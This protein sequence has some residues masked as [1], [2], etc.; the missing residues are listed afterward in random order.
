MGSPQGHRL[1]AYFPWATLA[2]LPVRR[3]GSALRISSLRQDTTLAGWQTHHSLRF[4]FIILGAGVVL[5][6]LVDCLGALWRHCT[7]PAQDV[8]QDLSLEDLVRGS[9]L[10]DA[11]KSKFVEELT[12]N[13]LDLTVADWWG[14]SDEERKE[15][16]SPALRLYMQGVLKRTEAGP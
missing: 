14:M 12:G 2:A 13:G 7:S 6:V 5:V 15:L 8:H 9:S 3:T 4:P 16:T 1:P 10:A 11:K